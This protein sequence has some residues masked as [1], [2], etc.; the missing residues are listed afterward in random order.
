MCDQAN[1][2]TVGA[3]GLVTWAGNWWNLLSWF[4]HTD[5]HTHTRTR[6]RKIKILGEFSIVVCHYISGC[7]DLCSWASTRWL[8]I[9]H[10]V[11]RPLHSNP[12]K[13]FDLWSDRTGLGTP[14]VIADSNEQ[15]RSDES[16]RSPRTNAARGV[17]PRK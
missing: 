6:Y 13:E 2:S 7:G 16:H 9:L 8:K 17:I 15:V 1:A 11:P 4:M 3:V 14:P 10:W 5:A 12:L